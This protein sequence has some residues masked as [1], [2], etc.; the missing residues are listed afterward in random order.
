MKGPALSPFLC[1]SGNAA[2]RMSNRNFSTA[3]GTRES[4]DLPIGGQA[5]IEGVMIRAQEKIVTAVRTPDRG[6][7]VREEE[8]IPWS[9]RLRLLGVPVI[10][11]AVS[12]F[13]MAIIGVRTL[14][15]SAEMAMQAEARQQGE[16]EQAGK[17]WQNRAALVLTVAISLAAGLGIFFFLPLFVAELRGAARD[18]FQFNLLAGSVRLALFILYLWGL[19]HWSEIRRVFEYHGAEHKSIYTQEAGD[20]L[21][22]VRARGYGRLHP[23]CG[24]SFL[25]IVVL[26]SILAFALV[27]SAV[28]EAIGRRQSLLERFATHL[29]VLPLISGVSFELLKLSGRK[30]NHPLTRLLIA[31]GLWLQR[32]TTR[33]PD[34]AQLEVA[35]VALRCALGLPAVAEYEIWSQDGRTPSAAPAEA[36]ESPPGSDGAGE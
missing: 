18:A 30:R 34:D 13:E 19:S 12:F 10:R 15:F 31:P 7:L 16:P 22:V 4:E 8:H 11:G 32:I 25:L 2:K 33:E 35:L 5:V 14:N 29:C 28:A 1:T 24:T 3:Q 21:T 20:D 9:R 6:I 26:I 17:S 23:R 36:A 27:D